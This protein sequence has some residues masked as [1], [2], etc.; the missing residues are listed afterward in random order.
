MKKLLLGVLAIVAMVATSCESNLEQGVNGGE[1]S[2]VTFNVTSPEL[3]TRVYSDGTT[4]THLQYAV[5]DAQQNILDAFTTTN[6]TINL[7]KQVTLQLTTGNTYYVLFWAAAPGAPYI[8]DLENKTLEIDYTGAKCNDETRDAFYCYKSFTVT[9]AINVDV[10]LKRPFAQLNVGTNDFATSTTA[11]YTVKYSKVSVPSYKNLNFATGEV[12][13][14]QT[15]EYGFNLLPENESFPVANYEYLAMA[16]VLMAADAENVDLTFS[17]Y[18]K[19]EDDQKTRAVGSVPMQR[20]HRT[21]LFGTILTSDVVF[22]VVI[23]P[24]YDND[25]HNVVLQPL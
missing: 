14:L 12:S 2:T 8:V 19:S 10:E 21:N 5:Y 17:Y 13:N 9:G 7:Q 20:N 22:D 25:D 24:G 15:V 18:A 3:N 6:E 16:Y 23:K 11:G 1:T 4:A